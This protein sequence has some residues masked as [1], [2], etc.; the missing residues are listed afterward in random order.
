MEVSI[1]RHIDRMQEIAKVN[2]IQYGK[3]P[4]RE[5]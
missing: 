5:K 4:R 1:Q 2:Y 3:D